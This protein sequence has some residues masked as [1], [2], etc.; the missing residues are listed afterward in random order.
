[1]PR[2]VAADAGRSKHKRRRGRAGEASGGG[3]GGGI[4]SVLAK[5][6]GFRPDAV[7]GVAFALAVAA[8]QYSGSQSGGSHRAPPKRCPSE[9]RRCAEGLC[10]RRAMLE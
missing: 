2:A 4:K 8:M 7:V 1:M 3:G 9:F 6:L 5:I 10:R